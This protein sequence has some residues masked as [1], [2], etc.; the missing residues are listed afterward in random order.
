MATLPTPVFY[1]R[2]VGAADD[3]WTSDADGVFNPTD[4]D[5][6]EVVTVGASDPATIVADTTPAISGLQDL[7]AS[8]GTS[9]TIN[10]ASAAT[11]TNLVYS[12][13]GPAWLSI[14][15]STGEI[16]GTAPDTNDVFSVTVTVSNSAGSASDSFDLTVINVHVFVSAGQSNAVGQATFDSGAEMPSGTR[17][18]NQA[19]E[20]VS[21]T[22]TLDHFSA[23]TGTMGLDIEFAR[24]YKAANP[25]ADIV[26]VPC[27]SNGTGFE[28]NDWGVG[29]T[30]YTS[31][32][33]RV[34]ALM[35]AN[36]LFQLKGILW[37]QGE[38]DAGFSTY[39]EELDEQFFA[40]R[41]NMTGATSE[42]PIVLGQMAPG[43]VEGITGRENIQEIITN[44]PNRVA[45]SAVASS[46]GLTT[47]D[48]VHY[49]AASLRT[50]G[51]R[52]FDALAV[53]QENEWAAEA[54]ATAHWVLG[55]D[56][57]TYTDLI[58]GATMTGPSHTLNSGFITSPGTLT[59]GLDTGI[60][61]A[62]TQTVITA[63]RKRDGN[64]MIAGTPATG[65]AVDGVGM[66]IAVN[67]GHFIHQDPNGDNIIV[68]SGVFSQTTDFV[69]SAY[70]VDASTGEYVAFFG[71]AGGNL[72]DTGTFT[73]PPL[74][75]S[76]RNIALG[77]KYWDS[78][79]FSNAT[80]FAEII[81]FPTALTLTQIEAVYARSITRLTDRGLPVA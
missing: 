16:T 68:D 34:N 69:I 61:E 67:R 14:D 46:T 78:L 30:L 64:C 9:V 19:G 41:D 18:W 27:G 35:A 40:F 75:V 65:G 10:A 77:N 73:S 52:H 39:R 15:S 49:D 22:I 8:S 80:D 12:L 28:D 51:Q 81:I 55:D 17:Q 11:G 43:F 1:W 7:S 60:A 74:N 70:S 21:A 37:Q 38:A 48:A 59:P 20:L 63:V 32:V 57:P 29:N 53:A 58:T 47:Q 54:G 5:E 23:G 31:T 50:L 6:V 4:G 79:S 13:S 33:S 72:T 45:Y 26:F 2:P 76:T 42:T 3:A 44:T 56:N 66:F 24:Q 25:D 36:P 62:S 71:D